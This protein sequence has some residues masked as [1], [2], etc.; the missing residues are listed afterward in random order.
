V[1]S[2]RE[3]GR[4]PLTEE[5]IEAI[6]ARLRRGQFL[7]DHYR[8]ALFRQPKEYELTYAAK[9]GRG[10]ILAE[11]MAVPLQ[12]LKRFGPDSE[13]WINRLVSG[14]N[15]QVLKTLFEMKERGELKNADG[16][17]GVRLCYIDPPFATKQEFRGGRGQKAYADKVIG[18]EFVEFLRKRL[19]LIHELLATDGVLYLHLDTK[20]VHYVKVL[21]DEIFG[22]NNFRSEIIWKRATAHSGANRYGPVHETLLFYSKGPN[23]LWNGGFHDPEQ[24]DRKGHYKKVDD[25][26]RRWEPGELTAP[27][28]RRGETGEEWRGFNPTAMG[29]HWSKPPADLDELDAEGRIYWPKKKGAW[30]RLIRYLDEAEGLALQ[31]V[32]T[33]I[34]PIN[35]VAKERVGYPT[36][37]PEALLERVISASSNPGDLVLDCFAGS[38]TTAVAAEKTGRR[39]AAVDCGKLAVYTTQRRLVAL[40]EGTGKQRALTTTQPFEVCTAGLYDNELLEQL[41]F[42]KY[43]RFCLDLFGCRPDPHRLADVAMV[44]SRKGGP[45]HLFP[46]NEVDLVMGREYI[47][48]LHQRLESKVSG[49]VY[50]IAPDS[51]CDP[52]LFEDMI[53]IGD[54]TYFIL[55]I[56]YSVIEALHGRDFELLPQPSSLDEVNDALDSFGFDFVQPPEVEVSYRRNK[57]QLKATIKS[58]QRGGL[59][60]AEFGKLDD[61]GRGDLAMVMIDSDHDGKVFRLTDHRFGDELSEDG[62][63][64]EI[65]IAGPGK[66]AAIIYLDTHGNE[67]REIQPLTATRKRARTKTGRAV[68]K[69]TRVRA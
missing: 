22:E 6:A 59:D 62:W 63:S 25:A 15:L 26:G 21:L 28:I 24:H 64:F 43:E 57:D 27:G 2:E 20:K 55:R 42:D 50:V 3:N 11:T 49:P 46:F 56:P 9:R 67:R 13:G 66:S 12:T 52:G 10:Q 48:S 30:P 69:A 18:A 35:M 23:Y 34:P 41:P 32:W 68:S 31:D 60:P 53:R 51:T 37:K 19:I 44:G 29:R 5:E 17:D 58:F 16:S 38:G 1:A 45:V 40:T 61:A 65:P 14:D 54:N 7:D 8:A 33:D 39:W 4:A 36:Q 47:E